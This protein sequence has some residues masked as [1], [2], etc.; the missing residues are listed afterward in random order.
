VTA[1]LGDLRRAALGLTRN[2]ADAEDL[3]QETLTKALASAHTFRPGTN[4]GAWLRRILVNTFISGYRRTQRERTTTVN[5]QLA[6][7]Q[8]THVVEAAQRAGPPSA[9][10]EA[11]R[12]LQQS[13][14]ERA[15]SELPEVYRTAVYLAD[16]EGFTYQQIADMLGIPLG[17]VQSRVHRG[18]R[19]LR[20]ILQ[21]QAPP[22]PDPRRRRRAR[23]TH[24]HTSFVA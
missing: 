10:D 23:P 21:R 24:H 14:A 1:H 16:V 7:P 19:R 3:V 17:T 13:T 22:N 15:L 4:L 11:L 6:G 2:R 18:R 20:T 12:R 8:L 9:E 5:W